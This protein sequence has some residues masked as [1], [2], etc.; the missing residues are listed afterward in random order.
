MS[1]VLDTGPI[2]NLYKPVWLDGDSLHFNGMRST[3]QGDYVMPDSE[4]PKSMH[5]IHISR[6]RAVIIRDNTKLNIIHTLG[7]L[8]GLGAGFIATSDDINPWIVIS[9]GFLGYYVSDLMTS[10]SKNRMV[11]EIDLQNDELAVRREKIIQLLDL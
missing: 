5:T 11:R 1:L 6:I 3:L 9:T 7:T 10:K 8:F 2:V 4:T